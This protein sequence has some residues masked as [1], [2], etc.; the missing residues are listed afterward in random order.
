[1]VADSVESRPSYYGWRILL[2][3]MFCCMLVFGLVLYSFGVFVKPASAEYGLSRADANNGMIAYLLGTAIWSPPVGRLLDRFPIR[4][5]MAAGAVTFGASLAAIGW[6]T[7]PL[8]TLVIIAGPLAAGC[9]AL[10]QL[11]IGVSLSRWFRRH[12]GK[13]VGL[14]YAA[15]ALGGAFVPPLTAAL[16]EAIGWRRTLVAE[17]VAAGILLAVVTVLVM[18]DWPPGEEQPLEKMGGAQPAVEQRA[19]TLRALI[20]NREFQAL[21]LALALIYAFDQALIASWMP[22]ASDIGFDIAAA[23]LA[24]AVLNASSI[25]GKLLCGVLVERIDWRVIFTGVALANGAIALMLVIKPSYPIVL[26]VFG[27][28]GT[29]VGALGTLWTIMVGQIFGVR[30]LGFVQGAMSF[31][32]MALSILAVRLAGES[33]DRTGGYD[34]VFG[35]F[36]AASVIAALVVLPFGR[37][38]HAASRAEP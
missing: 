36:A 16:V 3:V 25:L 33:F 14:A 27:G 22:Y 10:G 31:A 12:R 35:F 4:L 26:M 17:G 23:S 9:A 2:A 30:S 18:R 11:V 34:L 15:M 37:S 38:S 1:M 29:A 7:S 24:F 21:T 28:A 8:L 19:W 32:I 20:A 13:V 5:V 6:V